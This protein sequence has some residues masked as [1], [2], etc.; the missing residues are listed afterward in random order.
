MKRAGGMIDYNRVY[1]RVSCEN[2]GETLNH[3]THKTKPQDGS[4]PDF[5]RRCGH[6]A[7]RHDMGRYESRGLFKAPRW[8]SL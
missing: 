8:V 6:E 2:C 5:C 4:E 7:F 3:Y 1:S